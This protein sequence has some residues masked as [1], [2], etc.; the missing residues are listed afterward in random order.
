V[1]K[2]WV[3]TVKL[4]DVRAAR[5]ES[6]FTDRVTGEP[7]ALLELVDRG[8]VKLFEPLMKQ[9]APAGRAATC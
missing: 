5:V 1:G 7:D 9:P 8:V 3:L 2:T 6:R 4:I